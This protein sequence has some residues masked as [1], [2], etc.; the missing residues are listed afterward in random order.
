M[1]CNALVAIARRLKQEP[2]AYLR[3][4]MYFDAIAYSK[5][6]LAALVDTVGG[7]RIMFGTDNPFFPPPGEEE[8]DVNGQLWPSTMKVFQTIEQF[9]D[10]KLSD[11]ILFRNAQSILGI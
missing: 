9:K 4:N 6:A 5:P 8:K 11:Q 7:D 3:S 2:S 1:V 10:Q